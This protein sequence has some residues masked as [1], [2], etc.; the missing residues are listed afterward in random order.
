MLTIFKNFKIFVYIFKFFN[1]IA[2]FCNEINWKGSVTPPN[3]NPFDKTGVYMK[4]L[5]DPFY[6]T[7][8][9]GKG[10]SLASDS[11]LIVSTL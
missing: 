9:L 3:S 8:R 7:W 11:T 6:L 4:H 1:G 5:R 10:T 2:P